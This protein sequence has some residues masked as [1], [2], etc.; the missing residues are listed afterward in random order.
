MT[1][2][3]Q[4][5]AALAEVERL[6]D[7]LPESLLELQDATLEVDRLWRKALKEH[8]EYPEWL[9]GKGYGNPLLLS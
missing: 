4:Y 2:K 3:D 5:L 9:S 1:T 7:L 8:S 6:A